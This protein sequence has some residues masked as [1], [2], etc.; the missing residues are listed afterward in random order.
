MPYR[1]MIAGETWQG[2]HK[3]VDYRVWTYSEEP[4]DEDWKTRANTIYH[5]LFSKIPL[6]KLAN[7]GVKNLKPEPDMYEATPVDADEVPFGAI[8]QI[9]AYYLVRTRKA[10][11]GFHYPEGISEI[12]HVR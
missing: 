8:G 3:L 4:P 12:P 2:N 11:Y 6:D 7:F 1:L 10:G 9:R 5:E